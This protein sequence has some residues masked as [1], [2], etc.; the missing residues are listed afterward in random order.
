M[1]KYYTPEIS[2]LFIGYECEL[3]KVGC[4]A[5]NSSECVES[6]SK[7]HIID[8]FDFN[9]VW[10]IFNE[11][12]ETNI[13][14]KCLDRE[15]IESLG[16]EYS[17]NYEAVEDSTYPDEMGFLKEMEDNKTQYLLYYNP[18]ALL[19]RIEK[20]YDCGVEGWIYKGNCLSK[21]E[22]KTIM[23]LLNIK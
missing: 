4:A 18:K 16:W 7:Y 1:N 22:L 23:K 14:T 17:I 20:V 21:N 6:W 19:L 5:T 11:G 10:D 15:D 2:D 9:H 12:R 8:S 3:L 13:R